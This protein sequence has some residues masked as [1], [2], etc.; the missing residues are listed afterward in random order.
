MNERTGALGQMQLQLNNVPWV[1][2]DSRRVWKWQQSKRC[3]CSKGAHI[4]TLWLHVL[5]WC[6]KKKPLWVFLRAVLRPCGS[7]LPLSKLIK[8]IKPSNKP[9]KGHLPL[10]RQA[11]ILCQKGPQRNAK[12]HYAN[13]TKKAESSHAIFIP[14]IMINYSGVI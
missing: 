9:T 3:D 5:L 13:K 4:Y 14:S 2:G 12:N 11:M 8:A 6:K 10:S 1:I 7:Q